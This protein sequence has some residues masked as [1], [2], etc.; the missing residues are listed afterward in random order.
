MN[1]R[2]YNEMHKGIPEGKTEPCYICGDSVLIDCNHPC[3]L[4]GNITS[5]GCKT[6]AKDWRDNSFNC[7]LLCAKELIADA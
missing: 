4:C 6:E 5:E 7:C 3:E 1:A 2:E